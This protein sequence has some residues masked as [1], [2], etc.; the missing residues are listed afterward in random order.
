MVLFNS[1]E[2]GRGHS[3]FTPLWGW[4]NPKGAQTCTFR[5][6]CEEPVIGDPS[7][8]QVTLWL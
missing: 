2:V 7:G 3:M 5:G 4:E 8:T 1:V 6:D